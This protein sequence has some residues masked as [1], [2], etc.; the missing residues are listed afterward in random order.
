MLR[1]LKDR[2]ECRRAVIAAVW[3]SLAFTVVNYMTMPWLIAGIPVVETVPEKPDSRTDALISGMTRLIA[4]G[5]VFTDDGVTSYLAALGHSWPDERIQAAVMVHAWMHSDEIKTH[6]EHAPEAAM[7][8]AV[9]DYRAS[10]HES[11]AE[12]FREIVGAYPGDPDARGNYG[13]TL[14]MLGRM[15]EARLHL[16]AVSFAFPD[17]APGLLNLAYLTGVVYIEVGSTPRAKRLLDRQP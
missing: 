4:S 15:P 16:E 9:E 6:T 10:R 14:V 8:R 12:Q 1:E 17:H 11:A 5:A 7:R 2:I 3:L 13:L